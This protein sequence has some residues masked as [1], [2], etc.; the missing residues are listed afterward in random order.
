MTDATPGF[1]GPLLQNRWRLGR[2]LGSGAQGTTRVAV[3][4][5]DQSRVAVKS[6]VL[7][8]VRDWKQLD[9]FRRE[10]AVL[11]QLNHPGIPRFL[12]EITDA[13]GSNMHLVME[14][15][16]GEN[17]KQRLAD[18]GPMNE[19]ALWR[20]LWQALDI[21]AYLHGQPTPVVHRDIKP[22][23]IV[24]R[25]DGSL[26]LV[27]FGTVLNRPAGMGG[28]TFVG[29][30]G[31]M[32]PELMHGDAVAASDVY[33]LGVTLLCLA[34]GCEPEDLPRDGLRIKV[35]ETA[36]LSPALADLLTRM[37]ETDPTDRPR[38]AK[39][40]KEELEEDAEGKQ[41]SASA[42]VGSSDD[43]MMA[44]LPARWAMV[45]SLLMGLVG[46]LASV[47]VMVADRVFIPAVFMVLYALQKRPEAK[48]RVRGAEEVAHQVAGHVSRSL[49]ELGSGFLGEAQQHQRRLGASGR[50]LPRGGRKGRDRE[51]FRRQEE[52]RSQRMRAR[53][54]KGQR[55]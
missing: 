40:L 35:E 19:A 21:L 45:L 15:V 30:A 23:N 12:A 37:T 47:A 6:L 1:D 51:H 53:Q 27:D 46:T 49:R 42:L 31:F 11:K 36:Q 20:V 38:N 28:N 9:L 52:A 14:L 50:A 39:V 22:A 8:E 10:A 2:L 32:A 54:A 33:A 55:R 48:A 17:L 24:E 13:D 26:A 16:P 34:S 7:K 29:T 5:K 4:T 18:H 43:G 44:P 25:P 3:D 41:T